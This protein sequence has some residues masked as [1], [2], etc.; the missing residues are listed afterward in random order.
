MGDGSSFPDSS[1]NMPVVLSLDCPFDPDDSHDSGSS[2]NV[3][4]RGVSWD[5]AQRAAARMMAISTNHALGEGEPMRLRLLS[6]E[7]PGAPAS[8]RRSDEAHANRPQT[9][10]WHVDGDES[11]VVLEFGRAPHGSRAGPPLVI[12]ASGA[13]ARIYEDV[14]LAYVL[15]FCD[16]ISVVGIDW[17]DFVVIAADGSHAKLVATSLPEP[18]NN[19]QLASVHAQ[20]LRDAAHAP[21][22]GVYSALLGPDDVKLLQYEQMRRAVS[23]AMPHDAG[24]MSA[25]VP[26]G[27]PKGFR[28]V[29]LLVFGEPL[30][31]FEPPADRVWQ[32]PRTRG[33]H[34]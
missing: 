30:P 3:M 12:Q 7:V 10:V 9:A 24:L 27:C 14:L 1:G 13:A 26:G 2:F 8:G 31:R 11:R 4:S 23:H 19:E 6:D 17:A 5:D 20:R 16:R 15:P 22:R 25:F 29:S 21:V 33:S 34:R 18:A 32:T 28:I